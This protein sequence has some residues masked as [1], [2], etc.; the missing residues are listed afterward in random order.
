MI[1]Q[2]FSVSLVFTYI[3]ILSS[4]EGFRSEVGLLFYVVWNTLNEAFP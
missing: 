1:K 3:V 4:L 2:Q